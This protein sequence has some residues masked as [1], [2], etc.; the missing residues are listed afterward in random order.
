MTLGGCEAAG[1]GED[2]LT[3]GLSF[4]SSSISSLKDFTILFIPPL[5]ER[6]IPNVINDLKISPFGVSILTETIRGRFSSVRYLSG[7]TV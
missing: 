6:G 1:R 7:Q 3:G 5:K 2:I 4:S